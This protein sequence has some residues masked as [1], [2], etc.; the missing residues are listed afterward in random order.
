[1]ELFSGKVDIS[2]HPCWS[3]RLLHDDP[4]MVRKIHER[5]LSSGAEIITSLSYQACPANLS[6]AFGISLSAAEQLMVDSVRLAK[7]AIA[8]YHR[9]LLGDRRREILCASSIG[10]YGAHLADGSEYNGAYIDRVD[11]S[12]IREAYQ[13]QIAIMASAEPDLLAFETVPTLAE[14]RLI[15]ELMRQWPNVPA[16]LSMNSSDGRHTAHGETIEAAVEYVNRY[17]GDNIFAFGVN[18]IIPLQA[19]RDTVHNIRSKLNPSKLVV[20]YPNSGELW[21]RPN[22]KWYFPNGAGENT[23]YEELPS[24]I[25]AGANW[26]GG[27]CRMGSVRMKRVTEIIESYRKTKEYP[28]KSTAT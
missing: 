5:F 11:L 14:L 6:A 27:C 15:V 17:A 24:W 18:C 21:D 22:D 13:R 4:A 25:E 10:P 1:M 3:A 26:I 19:V 20:L 16:W 23:F 8:D 12:V 9:P 2:N 28:L 7:D